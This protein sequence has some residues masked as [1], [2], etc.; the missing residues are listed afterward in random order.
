MTPV[1]KSTANRHATPE[2]IP[3]ASE[4]GDTWNIV[5]PHSEKLVSL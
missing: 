3:V 5:G 4:A 1:M 2:S